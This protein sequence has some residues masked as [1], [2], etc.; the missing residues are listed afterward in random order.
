MKD[1]LDPTKWQDIFEGDAQ[2]V[3]DSCWRA[4]ELAAQND[5]DVSTAMPFGLG[6]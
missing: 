4:Q 2:G 6:C 5:A 1:L 3:V